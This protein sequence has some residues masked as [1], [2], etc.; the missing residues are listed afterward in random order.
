MSFLN[1]KKVLF[2]GPSNVFDENT[3]L[4]YFNEYDVIFINNKFIELLQPN[5]SKIKEKKFAIILLLNGV[6]TNGNPE[7]IKKYQDCISLFFVSETCLAQNLFDIGIDLKKIVSM[8]NNY[9]KF[10]YKG[11]P[12][13]FPKLIMLLMDNNVELAKF[14]ITGVTF[15]MDLINSE[16]GSDSITYH[17]DYHNW[18]TKIPKELSHLSDDE[19]MKYHLDK[20]KSNGTE[21]P[22]TFTQKH[23]ILENFNFFMEYYKKNKNIFEFDDVLDKIIKNNI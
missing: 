22:K 7:T 23:Y 3:D 4:S 11:C 13:M 17:K 6:F 18:E 20:I 1:N 15:Y 14:K 2:F 5:L 16:E 9:K 8:A 10:G 19:K 12:N 21:V